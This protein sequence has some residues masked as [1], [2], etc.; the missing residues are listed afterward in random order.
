MK[1]TVRKKHNYQGKA[2]K[3]G[4]SYDCPDKFG[5]VMIAVGKAE[6]FVEPEPEPEPPK[7]RGRPPR[8]TYQTRDM[9]AEG[10]D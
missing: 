6:P 1:I 7:R 2:R 4:A 10:E 8:S 3:V 5:R 9:K